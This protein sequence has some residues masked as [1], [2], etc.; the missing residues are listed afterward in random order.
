MKRP[1]NARGQ[2]RKALSPE[3]RTAVRSIRLSAAD[4]L[5]FVALGGAAWLRRMLN[6]AREQE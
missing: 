4:W 5:L 6:K 3:Q 1:P 2:G